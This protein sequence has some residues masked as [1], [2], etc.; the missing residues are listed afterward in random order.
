VTKP[1]A[2]SDS[3]ILIRT[4]FVNETL[5][6]FIAALSDHTGCQIHLCADENISTLDPGPIAG[7][8]S[9]SNDLF[10]QIGLHV[11]KDV[12]WR[13]GDYGI[14]AALLT[15]PS[16]GYF[17][18]IEPDVYIDDGDLADFFRFFERHPDVD[19]L[20]CHYE[21]ATPHWSWRKPMAPYA[22]EIYRC[23]FPL[24][25]VSRSAAE[26]L[27]QRRR[28]LTLLH[29]AVTA[30][31][32]AGPYPIW[33]ND[34]GF[35]A[36]ELTNAGFQCRDINDFGTAF[37]TPDSFGFLK[38]ISLKQVR[39]TRG[40][41]LVWHPVLS[42][43]NFRRNLSLY[44]NGNRKAASLAIETYEKSKIGLINDLSVECGD[45]VADRLLV[46]MKCWAVTSDK[47]IA[48]RP[49]VVDHAQGLLVDTEISGKHVAF[50][51]ADPADYIQSFHAKG[52]FY[53]DIELDIIAQY[54]LPG[55]ILLD[56]GAHT[57]NHILFAAT[58]LQPGK[59]I[60]IEP[61][62]ETAKAL[63]FNVAINK[64]HAIVDLRLL[65]IALSDREGL[66]VIRYDARNTGAAQVTAIAS[67][68]EAHDRPTCKIMP[69][70]HLL[71]DTK[72]DFIK[73]DV[74]GLMELQVL[75]GIRG[76]LRRDR[77]LLFIHV[78]HSER[79][80]I[81]RFLAAENYRTVQSHIRYRD[82]ECLMLLPA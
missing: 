28:A 47:S 5:L 50:F 75:V 52:E 25:R 7:K 61:N 46:Q 14:Y 63:R 2:Q 55:S 19:F 74:G 31:H 56:I 53:E 1:S 67:I 38:P 40:Y 58:F 73:L 16:A 82:G 49:T 62:P 78:P 11:T 68:D 32:Q 43:E 59:I 27:L 29:E 71:A 20:A 6:A 79:D 26:F 13:C 22:T 3:V 39:S 12:M 37:Y 36:T 9:L 35:C 66:G 69:G 80:A 45:M 10:R 48:Q 18:I 33:P 60:A 41:G 64:L 44:F 34:E 54:L 57:G 77:P 70:D 81:L 21:P 42:G 4:H 17:W 51:V 76:V 30:S 8:I 24:V 15:L 23:M 72:V 65:G